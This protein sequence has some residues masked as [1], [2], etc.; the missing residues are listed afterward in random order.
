LFPHALAAQPP[1]AAPPPSLGQ[2]LGT[3]FNT[4]GLP[5][6]KGALQFRV[7]FT[8][9]IEA[10][11]K[12]MQLAIVL[13]GTDSMTPDIQSAVA[14]LATVAGNL[15]AKGGEVEYAL[16]VYRDT[17][18]PSGPVSVP[19]PKFTADLPSLEQ[20]LAS[21]KTEDGAPYFAERVD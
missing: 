19:L 5:P 17:G 9:L 20:A 8:D 1:G 2:V 21:V 6:A 3:A 12:N 18:S 7:D 11:Q 14:S 15:Q 10:A 13:D 4:M 16:V